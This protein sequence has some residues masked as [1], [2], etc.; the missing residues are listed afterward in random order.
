[1]R[2]AVSGTHGSGK[3]TLIDDFVDVRPDYDHEQEPYWALVQQ[4]VPFADG[5][6]MDDLELQ[7]EQG[8]DMILACAAEPRVIFD[9]CPI[10]FIAY[11][12][13]LGEREGIE[14]TPTGKL[15][16]RM[17]RAMASL[18]LLVFLPLSVPDDIR[19]RIEFPR[20]RADVDARLKQIV[21]DDTLG[22]FEQER[23]RRLELRGTRA[24]RLRAMVSAVGAN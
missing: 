18:D 15:L 11:L 2:I 3:S 4:G 23:P 16:A 12:E 10:D 7:L 9:R 13:V 17:E 19:S 1:M 20:L 21:R 24:E 14:W 6:A 8:I 22:F 5:P